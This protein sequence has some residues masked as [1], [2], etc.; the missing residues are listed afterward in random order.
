MQVVS[1][2][3]GLQ[4]LP[5]LE[6]VVFRICDLGVLEM[7]I[8]TN[9]HIELFETLHHIL[10]FVNIFFRNRA[11]GGVHLVAVVLQTPSPTC[12]CPSG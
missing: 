2:G 5:H 10:L 4:D 6:E 8:A 12:P 1:P 7:Y 9:A 11:E 3:R